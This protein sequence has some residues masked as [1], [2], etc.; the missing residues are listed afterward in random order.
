LNQSFRQVF[1]TNSPALLADGAT[2]ENI[3]VGQV[4]FVDAKTYKGVTSPT[5]AKNKA[6]QIV[7]GTPDL[8]YLPLM[9]GVPNENVYSHLIKGKLIKNFRGKAAKRGRNQIITVGNSGDVS[10]TDTISAKSGDQKFFYLKLT[11]PAIDKLYSNQGITR[12]YEVNGGCVD[13]CTDTCAVLADPRP[14]A[15]SLALQINTDPYVNKFVKASVIT[16]CTPALGAATTVNC[17]RFEVRVCDTQ[18]DISLGIVQGQYADDKV[19]RIG[20]EGSL[21]VYQVVR[22]TNTLPADVSNAG[23][24][25]IPDC[26]TCP[27]GYTEVTSGYVYT[28]TRQDAGDAGA[29]NSVKAT[30]GIS[31]ST[32]SGARISY[33]FGQSIYVLV[34]DTAQT[35]QGSDGFVFAGQTRNSCVIAAPSTVA[36][37]LAETQVKYTQTYRIT[38]ADSICGTDRL[39]DIQA[40]FPAL[41]VTLVNAAGSCVHT[42]ETTVYSQCVSTGCSLDTLVFSAPQPFEGSEWVKQAEAALP[43]GTVCLVGV[44]IEVAFVNRI[45]GECTYDYFPYE[46]DTIHIQASNYDPNYNNSPEACTT[47]W[48]VKEIQSFQHPAGFGAHIRKM[49]EKSKSYDL[50]ERSFDP[51]VREI[52]GYSFQA[53]PNAYY[54]EYVLDFEFEYKVGGWSEKYTDSYSI[55]IFVPEG[56]GTSVENAVNS[57]I[58]SVGIDIDPVVL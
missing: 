51:V 46:S 7:Q 43:T 4:G 48:P 15:E 16:Q 35:V 42:Y 47:Y 24:I 58:S 26:P 49:E 40:A 11:G 6:L 5:Y 57:Y 50:R 37:G 2:V 13:D 29:L 55:S 18:D 36:W 22:D 45:T 30:Y 54:D 3:G 53:I 12:Q 20:K 56:Q 10:D 19:T 34:S 14:L 21:S 33:Q 1:V 25:L 44:K 23:F 31:S 52:E 28:V 8:S 9:A 27:S 41:V 17:Y 39:T 32:E 38:I